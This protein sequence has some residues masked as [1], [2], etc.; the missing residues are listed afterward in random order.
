MS[1]KRTITVGKGLIR[2]FLVLWLVWVSVLTFTSHKALLT[3]AGVSYW[4]ETAAIERN[5]AE[6][7]EVGCD[8]ASVTRTETDCLPDGDYLSNEV[9]GEGEV[10]DALTAFFLGGFL[11]PLGILTA[12]VT[13]WFLGRWAMSGFYSRKPD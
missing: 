11:L 9:I 12:L 13:L 10:K 6:R 4:T 3:A 8:D 5:R 2:V 7:K 1:E